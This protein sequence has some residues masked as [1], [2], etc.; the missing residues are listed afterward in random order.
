VPTAGGIETLSCPDGVVPPLDVLLAVPPQAMVKLVR[1]S[2]S[3]R[4]QTFAARVLSALRILAVPG[5]VWRMRKTS[6]TEL[7]TVVR[8]LESTLEKRRREG[9]MTWEQGLSDH[10]STL[11]TYDVLSG[12]KLT[13]CNSKRGNKAKSLLQDCA[14]PRDRTFQCSSCCEVSIRPIA[15]WLAAS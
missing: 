8:V 7:G 13:I 14:S 5:W 9:Q 10:G 1:Q 15:T 4:K 11:R 12:S 6:K 3:E 2:K